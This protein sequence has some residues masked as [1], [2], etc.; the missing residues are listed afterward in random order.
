MTNNIVY[1]HV[2]HLQCS[3]YKYVLH[4]I[5]LTHATVLAYSPTDYTP[6]YTHMGR[7]TL[8]TPVY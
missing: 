8:F 4:Y 6:S 3:A 1:L 2:P 7:Y 5:H